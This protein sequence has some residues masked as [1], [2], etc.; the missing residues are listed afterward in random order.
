MKDIIPCDRI[1]EFLDKNPVKHT[2]LYL[3]QECPIEVVRVK[4]EIGNREEI[5]VRR[6]SK[7]E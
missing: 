2:S 7:R 3:T 4:G 6:K 5:L 1:Q